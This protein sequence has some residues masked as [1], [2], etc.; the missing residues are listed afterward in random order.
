MTGHTVPQ[1]TYPR[2]DFDRSER[3]SSLDGLWEFRPDPDDVGIVQEWFSSDATWDARMRVPGIWEDP[4]Q[5]DRHNW[6]ETGWY[7]RRVPVPGEWDDDDVVIVFAASFYTTDV[8]V[9]GVHLARHVGGYT[10]FEVVVP[11]DRVTDATRV[12]VRVSAP[13]DKRMIPHGK[14]R[15]IPADDYDG[16]CF[17]P[18]SGIWSSVWLEPRN[19]TW[20]A[21]VRVTPDESLHEFTVDVTVSGERP[22]DRVV[23]VGLGDDIHTAVI[24]EDGTAHVTIAVP[25]PR[26]WTP[27]DPH[28]YEVAVTLDD[29]LDRVRTFA[30]MRRFEARRDGFFLNGEQ[31]YLRGVLDQGYWP[32]SGIT[33]PG[34]DAL[35]R[36]LE[37]ATEFGFNL[38]RKHIKPEDRRWYHLADQLGVLVW[39]E[40]P[41]PGHFSERSA[42]LFRQELRELAARDHNHPSIVMWSAYNEEWGLNW[43]IG[44]DPA[45]GRAVHDAVQLLRDVDGSRPVVDNSGWDHVDGD[46]IDW[47]Y[48]DQD[49][50]SFREVL[51]EIVAD[52]GTVLTWHSPAH[53]VRK[54]LLMP[55]FERTTQPFMNSEYGGGWNSL[56][57]AWQA[58]W[59]TLFM[60]AVDAN[61]GYIYT[62]L[63]DIEAEIVGM[64]DYDRRP[65]D[66]GTADPRD[67]HR[68]TV[69]IPDI[70]PIAPGHD[71]V[72][73]DATS[74]TIDVR[75]SHHGRDTVAGTIRVR[76]GSTDLGSTPV[77]AVLPFRVSQPVQVAVPL[78]AHLEH[79][80]V[81]LEFSDEHGTHLATTTVDLVRSRPVDNFPPATTASKEHV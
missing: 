6:L 7:R 60:R 51:P 46:V 59:Q 20:I 61:A 25:E 27:G 56:N 42:E 52:D 39:A 36:D 64:V 17:T 11:A 28:L 69:V 66:I 15:S 34:P 73:G 4:T 18:S 13:T 23:G 19:R 55:G 78:D 54:P 22:A 38:V 77:P 31:V 68:Q 75:V 72:V 43:E 71:L 49:P 70:D 47:H 65:K 57:R 30:G 35:R 44:A 10:P 40:A 12:V 76:S 29:G 67:V 63:Y 37:L 8:W 14:Q 79:G 21:S 3:W 50:V 53:P 41:N 80:T 81:V 1:G 62:E 58:K 16:C 33:P 74:V 5:P 26:L 2:P 32:D 24:G 9:D 48:Y 45:R